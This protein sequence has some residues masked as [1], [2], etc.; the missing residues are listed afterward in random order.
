MDQFVKNIDLK[1]AIE[2]KTHLKFNLET[3]P[4]I[5]WNDI[6]TCLSDNVKSKSFI[7]V[8]PNF[9]TVVHDT[10]MNKTITDV[11]K[12]IQM[13]N[14][15]AQVTAHLYIS[16]TDS[17][18]TFGWH[19][20]D[21]DVIFWQIQGTTLFSVKENNHFFDYRLQVNDLIYIPKTMEHNTK[22]ITPRAGISFGLAY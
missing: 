10:S 15:D 11:S 13:I 19:N 14:I 5:N 9:G 22:P 2:N 7:K 3:L 12:S 1:K 20:D 18:R 16:F 17:A 21:V 8:M 4:S 6:L